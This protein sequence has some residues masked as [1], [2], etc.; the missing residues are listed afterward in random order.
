MGRRTAAVAG[1]PAPAFVLPAMSPARVVVGVAVD[2]SPTGQP[3]G[4][5]LR[6]VSAQGRGDGPTGR[7]PTRDSPAAGP[8][9]SRR[10]CATRSTRST[11]DRTG[12][13][14]TVT[15]GRR[16]HGLPAGGSTGRGL[17]AARAGTRSASDCFAIGGFTGAGGPAGPMSN[18]MSNPMSSPASGPA[19]AVPATVVPT[20][21]APAGA[22]PVMPAP[23]TAVPATL[24]PAAVTVAIVTAVPTVG[25]S[26]AATPAGPGSTGDVVPSV[27]CGASR[28]AGSGYRSLRNGPT[29]SRPR[30]AVLVPLGRE[31]RIETT[32]NRVPVCAGTAR[33]APARAFLR[34]VGVELNQTPHGNARRFLR[35]LRKSFGEHGRAA[36]GFGAQPLISDRNDRTTAFVPGPGSH[37]A[38]VSN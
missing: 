21:A 18:P 25:V 38:T 36:G 22:G 15:R 19:A 23:T 26:P 28:A 6:P 12:P 27:T 10:S 1:F 20:T 7:R 2:R 4:G 35:P 37:P 34:S 9:L 14:V 24:L 33:R 17:P 29:C 8:Q 16:S 30:C 13:D 5:L 3:R 32:D 11:P 31:C